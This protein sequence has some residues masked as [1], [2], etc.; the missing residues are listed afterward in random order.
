MVGFR[1]KT[2][3]GD[4]EYLI[5]K[6]AFHRAFN[7]LGGPAKVTRALFDEGLVTLPREAYPV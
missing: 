5:P 1:H 6:A 2:A 7:T 3:D 4:H